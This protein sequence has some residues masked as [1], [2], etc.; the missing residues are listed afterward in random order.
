MLGLTS[1]IRNKPLSDKQ[2]K[3]ILWV[4]THVKPVHIVIFTKRIKGVCG[5]NFDEIPLKITIKLQNN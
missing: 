1:W 2:Y 4:N 3:K 5:I